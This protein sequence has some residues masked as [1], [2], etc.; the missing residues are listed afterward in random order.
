MLDVAK[1]GLDERIAAL[2]W[3]HRIEIAPGVFTPGVMDGAQR[4]SGLG[5]PEDLS[6]RSV[7]DI[8]AW[9]GFFSFEAERRGARHVV[10]VDSFSWSGEGWGT[11]DGFNLVHQT[12]CSAV[13]SHEVEVMDLS[14]ERL[15]GTF[16]VVFFF[17]V[18]YHMRD[19]LGAIERVA[20]VTG[21]Q[22][23][24]ETHTDLE[25][26]ERP[27]MAFYPKGHLWGDE[28]TYFGVNTPGLVAMLKDVGFSRVEVKGRAPRH[29]VIA[30]ALLHEREYGVPRAESLQQG[31]TVIHAWK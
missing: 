6:G 9:D 3:F 31:W 30:R 27:A 11:K 25:D 17:N 24:L 10:A 1:P 7:L 28:T 14:P 2:R 26:L 4:L 18:L 5:I 13:E 23:I 19:P 21:D 15:G 12:R 16:D 29:R 8:G 22:L 20:S